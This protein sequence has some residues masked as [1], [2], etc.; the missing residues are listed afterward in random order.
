MTFF[1]F[2]TIGIWHCINDIFFVIHVSWIS[3]LIKKTVG[4][5]VAQMPQW[6]LRYYQVSEYV[7]RTILF[8]DVLWRL[9]ITSLNVNFFW[10]K[11]MSVSSKNLANKRQHKKVWQYVKKKYRVVEFLLCV[12]FCYNLFVTHFVLS[13]DMFHILKNNY[14]VS[15]CLIERKVLLNRKQNMYSNPRSWARIKKK[16]SYIEMTFI[17]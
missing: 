9:E 7:Q 15:G 5:S 10:P 14:E 2:Y 13:N 17:D 6:S 8:F 4:S 16:L 3:V 11:L 12:F 1:H